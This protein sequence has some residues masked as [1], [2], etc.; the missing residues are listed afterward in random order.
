MESELRSRVPPEPQLFFAVSMSDLGP[1]VKYACLIFRKYF[2]DQIKAVK[3][4]H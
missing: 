3:E 1:L 4:I 2:Y